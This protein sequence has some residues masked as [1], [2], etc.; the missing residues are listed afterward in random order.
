MLGQQRL[1]QTRARVL[2]RQP[3]TELV[4]HRSGRRRLPERLTFL[5]VGDPHGGDGLRITG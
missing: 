2:E 4:E 3:L 5:C 1:V